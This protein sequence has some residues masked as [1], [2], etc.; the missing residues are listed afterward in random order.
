L[1][2]AVGH[3][4]EHFNGL[5]NSSITMDYAKETPSNEEALMALHNYLRF[6]GP[7]KDRTDEMADVK[8]LEEILE[9]VLS[10]LSLGHSIYARRFADDY[11]YDIEYVHEIFALLH[12]WVNTSRES[13]EPDT[14]D[15]LYGFPSTMTEVTPIYLALGRRDL[16][17]EYQHKVI[18]L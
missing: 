6:K 2:I 12:P 10:D 13:F 5:F 11:G 7:S 16:K 3:H 18:S 1:L 9:K 14:V 15:E 8:L 17:L 4:Y